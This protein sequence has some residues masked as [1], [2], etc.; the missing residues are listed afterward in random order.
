ML[1]YLVLSLTL[2]ASN[3]S[4][5]EVA[6]TT[7]SPEVLLRKLETARKE[8]VAADKALRAMG[9]DVVFKQDAIYRLDLRLDPCADKGYTSV[10]RT[11]EIKLK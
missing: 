6:V 9:Y 3:A 10:T 2:V 5:Q 4:A 1:K 7:P 11:L 8:C